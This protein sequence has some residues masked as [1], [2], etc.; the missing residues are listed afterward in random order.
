MHRVGKN[1]KV[2]QMNTE[3]RTPRISTDKEF[4]ECEF[5]IVNLEREN[6]QFTIQN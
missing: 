5:R 3:D 4:Q 1:E 2:P 6:Q